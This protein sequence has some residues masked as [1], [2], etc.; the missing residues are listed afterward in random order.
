MRYFFRA[1]WLVFKQASPTLSV[2]LTYLLFSE[3]ALDAEPIIAFLTATVVTAIAMMTGATSKSKTFRV[4]R[5]A[6]ALDWTA[7]RLP[8]ELFRFGPFEE[9][10]PLA[11]HGGVAVLAEL[12]LRARTLNRLCEQLPVLDYQGFCLASEFAEWQRS[13][14]ERETSVPKGYVL[15]LAA[16]TDQVKRNL[17][18]WEVLNRQISKAREALNTAWSAFKDANYQEAKALNLLQLLKDVDA[19]Q[20]TISCIQGKQP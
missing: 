16:H 20:A 12:K 18:R 17:Q 2:F 19:S 8:I 9:N 14:P 15:V 13:W 10:E 6:N 1:I 5:L 7:A 3:Y 4:G 11:K